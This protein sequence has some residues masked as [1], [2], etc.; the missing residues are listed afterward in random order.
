M[1]VLACLGVLTGTLPVSPAAV[2][3]AFGQWMAGIEIGADRYWGGSAETGGEDRS[4]HPYRPTIFGVGLEHKGNP[5]G[6]GLQIHYSEASLGLE[7]PG[8]VV[9]VGGVFTIVSFSPEV[10][11][12]LATLGPVTELR[13]RAGPLF[14]VWDIIDEDTKTH[15]GVHT[16]VSLDIPFGGRF[17]GSVRAGAAFTP[18]PFEPEQLE[19]PFEP[20]ALWRRRFAAGLHYRL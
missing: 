19:S 18:S 13:L 1:R 15:L 8:A 7:G 11:Y 12:R 14:E 10:T 5:V 16:A 9:A 4:F 3:P 20:R 6:W 17:A 2:T